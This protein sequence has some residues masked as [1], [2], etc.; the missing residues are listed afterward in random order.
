MRELLVPLK[1]TKS[2]YCCSVGWDPDISGGRRGTGEGSNSFV[3]WY[4]LQNMNLYFDHFSTWVFYGMC[5]GGGWDMMGNE[6]GAQG[7][8][9]SVD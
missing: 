9:Q 6:Q 3:I 5:R 7:L 1:T 2:F 4:Y 8:R